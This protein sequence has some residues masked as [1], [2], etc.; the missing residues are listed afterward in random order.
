MSDETAADADRANADRQRQLET[1]DRL[2]QRFGNTLS[3]AFTR[4]AAAGRQLDGVLGTLSTRLAS[5]VTRAAV[6][7][8]RSGI[9]GL[10]K[11]LIDAGGDAE[12]A[13]PFAH[14]GV[15]AGGR[16]VPFANGG[17]VATPTYFPMA[18]GLGLMGERGAEAVM[19]LARGPDGR[20]G[21]AA[22]SG[23]RPVSVNV[24]IATP[25]AESFRRSQAQVAAGLARAVARGHR[26]S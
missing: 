2:A 12:S 7:P 1:L 26:A 11:G 22:Q 20:L 15:L 10:V 8:L 13:T 9:E 21:V 3:S 18:Q 6:K 25:D 14:G 23:G 19:P 16:V 4:N 24:T 5:A 17:V